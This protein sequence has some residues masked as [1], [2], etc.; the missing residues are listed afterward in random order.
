M[1]AGKGGEGR[2]IFTGWLEGEEKKSALQR[3]ALL[4]LT[5]Y[6]E[7]FGLCVVEAL[8]CGVPVLVS[9]HV[10]L[11]PEIEGAGAGWVAPL[12]PYSLERTLAEALRDDDGRARRGVA[13]LELMRRDFSWESVVKRLKAVY[14]E[15]L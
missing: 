12:D 5:S 8:A 14:S 11:A 10:N 13:G 1:V 2:V 7:N 6:Q 3:A 9:P 4:A 15:V